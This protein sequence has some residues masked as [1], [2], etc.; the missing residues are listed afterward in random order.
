MHGQGRDRQHRRIEDGIAKSADEA[1]ALIDKGGGTM[2]TYMTVMVFKDFRSKSVWACPVEGKGVSAA[3]WPITQIL[4][5]L[6][7]C[8]LDG[9]RMTF[10]SHQEPSIVEIQNKI[11]ELQRHAHAHRTSIDNSKV[12]A[13]NSSARVERAI[14]ELGGVIRTYKAALES[15]LGQNFGRD[16]P[17]VPW[18]VKRTATVITRDLARD[19]GN[20]SYKFIK[21]RQCQEP[22]AEFGEA[23]FFQAP[24]VRRRKSAQRILARPLHRRHMPGHVGS[25]VRDLIEQTTEC[26]KPTRSDEDR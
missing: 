9:C 20:T 5:E 13:S 15:R 7:T 21:G 1:D 19:G 6:D 12:V 24:T 2:R 23:V 22:A 4:E 11:A 17:T 14:Q 10:K 26:S 25:H 18:M 8:G 3:E 16:H